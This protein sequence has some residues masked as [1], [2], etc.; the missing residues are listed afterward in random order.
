MPSCSAI[1]CQKRSGRD[2]V[3]FHR[4]PT[5]NRKAWL[6]KIKRQG[7]EKLSDL[8]ICSDHFETDCFKR[9]MKAELMGTKPEVELKKNAIP[10]IFT[11][12][13][14]TEKRK[15]SEARKHT[16]IVSKN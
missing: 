6:T 14:S 3:S 2:A 8:R 15:L 4:L 9:D 11:F 12:N 7:G 1:G 10:T 5:T 13:P 16:G